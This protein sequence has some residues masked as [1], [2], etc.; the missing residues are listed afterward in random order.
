[1]TAP[2]AGPGANEGCVPT[3]EENMQSVRTFAEEVFGNKNLTYAADWLADDFVNG[4]RPPTARSRDERWPLHGGHHHDPRH[5]HRVRPRKGTRAPNDLWSLGRGRSG[6]LFGGEGRDRDVRRLAVVVKLNLGGH[7][8]DTRGG[9]GFLAAEHP[10]PDSDDTHPA[11]PVEC[12]A[13]QQ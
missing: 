12:A 2:T 11:P 4:R 1:M 8:I 10:L 6:R 13:A 9:P 3:P 5:G 7:E